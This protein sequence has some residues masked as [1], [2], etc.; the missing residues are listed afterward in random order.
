MRYCARCAQEVP[1]AAAFQLSWLCQEWGTCERC[2]KNGLCSG[3][4]AER[5]QLF[6]GLHRS[7]QHKRAL[8]RPQIFNKRRPQLK[9]TIPGARR[10]SFA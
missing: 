10:I 6:A 8:N 3:L 9:P 2:G 7:W 5:A 4:P 1:L